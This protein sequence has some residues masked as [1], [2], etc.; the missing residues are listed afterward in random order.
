MNHLVF[1]NAH[2]REL[3]AILSGVKTMAI[4]E[5]DPT[6]SPVSDVNSGD[7]LYFMRGQEECVVR[8]QATVV[9]VQNLIADAGEDLSHTLKELQPRLHLTEEQYNTWSVKQNLLLVEFKS[10]Q[11]T[12][13]IQVAPRYGTDLSK[14][15]A[16]ED[17]SQII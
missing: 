6:Q 16:F 10:A 9:R 4:I 3:E 2:A 12:S 14:W 8:V 13:V 7:C 17:F 5:N 11:K 1:L 15:V